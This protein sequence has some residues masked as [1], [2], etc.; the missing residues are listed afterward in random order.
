MAWVT[1]ISGR[2]QVA[3][4]AS[5]SLEGLRME[6][7]EAGYLEK[8]LVDRVMSLCPEC[9]DLCVTRDYSLRR[10]L[11]ITRGWLS[12]CRSPLYS[13]TSVLAQGAQRGNGLGGR[14][15]GCG[16]AQKHGLSFT[17][18][19]LLTFTANI[20]LAECRGWHL[21]LILHHP[22]R[23]HIQW[24]AGRCIRFLSPFE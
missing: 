24:V 15:R 21:S 20:H 23:W 16:S 17:K 18:A 2:W 5:R 6:E 13:V 4:F 9:G 14:N 1:W 10:W 7:P 22:S 12:L 19:D 8:W 11:S 3:W